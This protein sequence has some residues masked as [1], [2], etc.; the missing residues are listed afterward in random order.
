[1]AL[2][3]G[4]HARAVQDAVVVGEEVVGTQEVVAS[5]EVLDEEVV[6]AV[7]LV[8]R[9]EGE[10]V[11]ALVPG[12]VVLQRPDVLVEAVGHGAILVADVDRS[13]AHVLDGDG[14]E[15]GSR[16]A[17]VAHADVAQTGLVAQDG[18][19]A[20]L[21]LCRHRVGVGLE[22]IEVVDG[23]E[24]RD[25]ASAVEGG[26]VD[27]APAHHK[28]VEVVDVPV[29]LEASLVA[30]G[31][32][33][34]TVILSV[35]VDALSLRQVLDGV[36][37]ARG[38]V[39]IDLGVGRS[40]SVLVGIGLVGAFEVGEEEEF[41]LQD[42]TAEGEAKHRLALV[43]IGIG[44]LAT[45]QL[46]VA[47]HQLLVVAVEIGRTVELVGTTLG[48][49]VDGAAGE[50]ALA[51][52]KRGDVDLDLL[53]R[54]HGDWLGA[55]L[56]AV[57]AVGGQTKHVVVHRAVDLEGVVAVV[58]AGKRHGSALSVGRD[59]RVHARDVGDAVAH[60]WD[61]AD[62]ASVD[63]LRRSRLGGIYASLARDDDLLQLLGVVGERA[64]EVLR[65]TQGEADILKLLGL[66]AD[67]GDLH[68]VGA[69]HT[70]TLDG[71]AS[72]DV[73]HC[74]IDGARRI[75]GSRDS[76]TNDVVAGGKDLSADAGC[77]HLCEC[78]GEDRRQHHNEGKQSFLHN[79][80]N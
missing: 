13:V 33:V 30:P 17:L 60:R 75:V 12:E 49:G 54:L 38:L 79:Q 23:V 66:H 53:H 35:V 21:Q 71:E 22:A 51:N 56:A 76:C 73:G 72:I 52:V 59:L 11:V 29:D 19:E 45:G 67:V 16:G 25:A 78:R 70:H 32:G 37:N 65:L 4:V 63:A 40:Q 41:V 42:R 7:E 74:A 48:D 15:G 10:G 62:A 58:R 28:L 50:S 64:G 34:R 24:R 39:G 14:G 8:V 36:E 27:I 77:R 18:R 57:A 68:G 9:T 26:G 6:E 80:L 3:V 61:L 69:A 55:R 46:V 20:R 1:M 2:A 44:I 43:G 5:V 31:V 47:A